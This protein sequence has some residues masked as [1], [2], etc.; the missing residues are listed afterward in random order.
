MGAFIML[1][2]IFTYLLVC[3]DVES[4]P[5]PG[6]YIVCPL[7]KENVHVQN[8]V[9]S[10]GFILKKK[11]KYGAYQKKSVGFATTTG[12][13]SVAAASKN[14]ISVNKKCSFGTKVLCSDSDV[15]TEHLICDSQAI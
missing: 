6:L 3:G 4:N 1:S 5:G 11:A 12:Q 8:C 10:C 9:C 2:F 13:H 7:C 15:S 14:I